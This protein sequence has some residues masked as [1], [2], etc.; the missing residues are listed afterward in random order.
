MTTATTEAPISISAAGLADLGILH[1]AS[2]KA[3]KLYRTS[4][5]P[6]IRDALVR[7]VMGALGEVA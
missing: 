2:D 5:L 3:A 7:H 1:S 6:R 4:D